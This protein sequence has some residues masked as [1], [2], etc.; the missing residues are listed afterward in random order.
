MHNEQRDIAERNII[1]GIEMKLI[2]IIVA[3]ILSSLKLAAN[4]NSSDKLSKNI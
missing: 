1:R 4:N 2:I 3:L